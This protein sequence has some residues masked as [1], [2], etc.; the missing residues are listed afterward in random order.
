MLIKILLV[1]LFF[2]EMSEVF[3]QSY[4]FNQKNKLDP[5]CLCLKKE[6][7]CAQ[8]SSINL[9]RPNPLNQIE[10]LLGRQSTLTNNLANLHLAGKGHLK[11]GQDERQ[12]ISANHRAL[13]R[14]MLDLRQRINATY[15]W[16]KNESLFKGASAPVASLPS[17]STLAPLPPPAINPVAPS[18][19]ATS[20]PK[21]TIAP[22]EKISDHEKEIIRHEIA[23]KP[24]DY[25]PLETDSLFEIITKAYFRIA[26]PMLLLSLIHISSPR[27]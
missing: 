7:S 14:K 16:A 5:G 2:F 11:E 17:F 1:L 13:D 26:Y 8:L 12:E 23:R 3:S 9:P 20:A 21:S 27:D 25:R 24:K 22:E 18:A 10:L 4:C 6:S 15:P 19:K